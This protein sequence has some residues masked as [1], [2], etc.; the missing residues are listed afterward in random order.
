LALLNTLGCDINQG[1]YLHRPMSEA[2]LEDLLRSKRQGGELPKD[3][4]ASELTHI[5][6]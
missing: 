4:P 1:F 2:A 5:G 3:L 6:V